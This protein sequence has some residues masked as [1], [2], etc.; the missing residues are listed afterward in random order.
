MRPTTVAS[1]VPVTSP[2][3]EPEKLVAVLLT[4]V[5]PAPLPVMTPAVTVSGT[6]TTI[7]LPF[8]VNELDTATEFS[9]ARDTIS[10]LAPLAAAPR[11]VRAAAGFDAPVPP[12]ATGSVPE[13]SVPNATALGVQ[14][15]PLKRRSWLATGGAADTLTP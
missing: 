2:A 9:P 14:L 10:E 11:A 13:T 1:C 12:L 8:A 6:L 4:L 3:R 15:L 7:A 5:R